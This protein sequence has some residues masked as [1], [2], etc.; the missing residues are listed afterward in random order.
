MKK[1]FDEQG[2]NGTAYMEVY[3]EMVLDLS[4]DHVSA[5]K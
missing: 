3:D 4:S 5:D 1:Q 2:L